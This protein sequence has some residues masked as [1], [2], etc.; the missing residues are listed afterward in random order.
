ME[1]SNKQTAIE[2]LIE[3][4][5]E[6]GHLWLTD[7]PYSMDELSLIIEKAKEMEKEQIIDA[8][9]KGE[10]N[11]G[12]N[13]DAKQYYNETY[14]SK[15][16]DAKDVILGYKTSLDAQM[17]DRIEPKQETLDCPFDF[18]SRCTMGSC[19]CKPKQETVEEAAEIHVWGGIYLNEAEKQQTEI[20]FIEGANWQQERMYS[21]EDMTES[22]M[23]CWKANVS[24]GIECKLSFKEWFEQFKKK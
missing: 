12:C 8:Y 13:E 4:T 5:T 22:F 6:S 24:D 17:L 2:W 19:D 10:F 21:E 9:D 11:Q 1:T 3:K 16:S 20:A 23:A 18:T 15:E 7:K 14:E